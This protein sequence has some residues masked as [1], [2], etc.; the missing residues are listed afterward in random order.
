M[1]K[2]VFRISDVPLIR[3]VI[4]D[5]EGRYLLTVC[6][7]VLCLLEDGTVVL[8]FHIVDWL[9]KPMFLDIKHFVKN[10]KLSKLHKISHLEAFDYNF[11]L[12]GD[13]YGRILY[14]SYA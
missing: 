10:C 14:H 9:S 7:K 11:L 13:V 1:N 3:I 12:L 4:F 8:S 2:G 6:R 5:S